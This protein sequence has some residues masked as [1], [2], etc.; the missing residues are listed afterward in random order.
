MLM[1]NVYFHQKKMKVL[2]AFKALCNDKRRI[3]EAFCNVQ[4]TE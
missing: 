4:L 1:D 3:N 2:K